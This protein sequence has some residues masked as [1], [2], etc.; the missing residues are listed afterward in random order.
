V[1]ITPFIAV[2]SDESALRQWY[3]LHVEDRA[4]N[5][6]GLPTQPFAAFAARLRNPVY[7]DEGTRY[8]W[9]AWDGA[10]L[11]GF[12]TVVYPDH[13]TLD[14][15]TVRVLVGRSHR[16]HGVGTA[17]LR[18]IVAD[19]HVRGRERFDNEQ[20]RI[21]TDGEHW[22]L[23]VG[24]AKVLEYH[25]RTLEVPDV[26]PALWDVP[27]PAG[28]RLEQWADAAPEALVQAFAAAR[29]AIGD[30]PTGESDYVHPEWTVERVRQTEADLRA[31]GNAA[32]YYVDIGA[33]DA[34]VADVGAALGMSTHTDIPGPRRERQ[35]ERAEGVEQAEA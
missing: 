14:R 11:L 21:G 23:S 9:T 24:F 3:D 32:R 30:A 2:D 19:A 5:F 10:Q 15:G 17:L 13:G 22:A 28:F 35:V 18:E 7:L 1:E 34:S 31:A 16:R 25:W 12:G 20:V 26:D 33:F 6:P 27:V 4:E 29:N 8:A